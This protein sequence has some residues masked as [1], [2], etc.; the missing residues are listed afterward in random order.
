MKFVT[1]FRGLAPAALAAAFAASAATGPDLQWANASRGAIPK[2]SFAAG[3]DANGKVLYA[4]RA[5]LANGADVPGKIREPLIGCNV[6]YGG[7]EWSIGSYQVLRD[8][9]KAMRW[10]AADSVPPRAYKVGQEP[11]GT[12]VFLC[13]A[14]R[15]DGSVQIGRVGAAGACVYGMAGKEEQ[16]TEF[17]VLARP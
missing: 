8:D 10:V 3:Q 11:D 5:R 15:A 6:V 7:L 17:E 1:L 4:C 9:P 14:K 12:A 2:G 16:A 13:R